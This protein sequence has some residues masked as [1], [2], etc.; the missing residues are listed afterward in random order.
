MT[1]YWRFYKSKKMCD[2]YRDKNLKHYG[3][4]SFQILCIMRKF[5]FIV[6]KTDEEHRDD[7]R[8]ATDIKDVTRI[9]DSAIL[10]IKKEYLKKAYKD[11]S[12]YI[13][14]YAKFILVI[15]EYFKQC[16]LGNDVSDIKWYDGTQIKMEDFA[17]VA[18]FIPK[19]FE[20]DDS[21]RYDI[22]LIIN[23]EPQIFHNSFKALLR[24]CEIIGFQ[25]VGNA[26]IKICGRGLL[27]KRI[28]KGQ[29]EQYIMINNDWY[30]YSGASI[31]PC[32]KV[33]RE[34]ISLF[35]KDISVEWDIHR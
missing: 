14:D 16:S 17:G 19:I 20:I 1:K 10:S 3:L 18:S 30:L 11:T 26:D 31:R 9:L 35:S 29:K 12:F 5:Q 24:L 23:G 32:V 21:F 4:T 2:I 8:N 6:E 33:M 25:R 7:F 15:A 22:R 34:I 13:Y 28:R 27:V